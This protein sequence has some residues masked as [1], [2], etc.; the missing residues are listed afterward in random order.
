MFDVKI[1]FEWD[2]I[3]DP[4]GEKTEMGLHVVVTQHNGN[5]F[6]LNSNE[7]VLVALHVVRS[8]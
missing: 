2:A 4:H 7:Y 3:L 5:R 1:V 8:R 6:H